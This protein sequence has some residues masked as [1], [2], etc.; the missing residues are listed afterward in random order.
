M[1]TGESMPNRRFKD[2]APG[3]PE[4]N[5]TGPRVRTLKTR[6][7]RTPAG[8]G[9]FTGHRRGDDFHPARAGEEKLL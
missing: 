6:L 1:S 7:P 8:H 3:S 4:P 2:G 5:P 9:A